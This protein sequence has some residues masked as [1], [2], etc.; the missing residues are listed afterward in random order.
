MSPLTWIL[1]GLLND[2][3]AANLASLQY[4][5]YTS[6]IWTNTVLL[7]YLKVFQWLYTVK[8]QLFNNDQ[9]ST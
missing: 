5:L 9:A 1:T 6:Q 4:I 7:C 3:F 2:F 8:C